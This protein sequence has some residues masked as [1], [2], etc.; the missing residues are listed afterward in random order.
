MPSLSSAVI[1]LAAKELVRVCLCLTVWSCALQSPFAVSK[2]GDNDVLT[3]NVNAITPAI[4]AVKDKDGH[5]ELAEF[6]A[7]PTGV[8]LGVEITTNWFADGGAAVAIG[9]LGAAH[10]ARV[11]SC[12]VNHMHDPTA[13]R[14]VNL[15]AKAV[16][17]PLAAAP[18]RR[19]SRKLQATA[20]IPRPVPKAVMQTPKRRYY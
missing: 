17:A 5:P 15:G 16:L 11:Q 9:P 18:T 4:L 14:H 3:L 19:L 7:N 12:C 13:M 8:T 1:V 6:V 2:N 10:T 20:Y